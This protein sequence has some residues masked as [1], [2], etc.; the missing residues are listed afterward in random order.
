LEDVLGYR[1]R[2]TDLLQLALTHR[3]QAAVHNERLEF[4]GDSVLNCVTTE[5]L[6]LRFSDEDEG[7]LSRMRANLVNRDALHA[8]AL[9][10]ELGKHL[11]LG[12]G[13]LKS[14]GAARPSILADTLEALIGAVFADGG[15]DAART[16]VHRCFAPELS[17]VTP[18]ARI[19]DAKSRLQ[20]Y[21]QGRGLAVPL[22]EV[23]ATTGKSHAQ[24]FRV[25]C[26]VAG[27]QLETEGEGRSRRAAEQE[28]AEK[29]CQHLM[30]S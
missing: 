3:S 1:F 12:E 11:L 15:F 5:A 26:T 13:E 21:L 22:Y 25:R 2:Q 6:F 28:A 27:C 20:E 18:H 19:K 7:K 24:S 4:L 30:P 23:L 16:M 17:D 29:A 9:R 14:G 10:L 8:V